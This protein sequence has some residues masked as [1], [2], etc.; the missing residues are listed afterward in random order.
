MKFPT[1]QLSPVSCHF[2]P[3]RSKHS[4]STP[5]SKPWSPS[6][7]LNVRDQVSNPYS[8]NIKDFV[9]KRFRLFQYKDDNSHALFNTQSD[10]VTKVEICRTLINLTGCDS[11]VTLQPDLE[12]KHYSSLRQKLPALRLSGAVQEWFCRRMLRDDTTKCRREGR[13]LGA[14][15][16]KW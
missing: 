16:W 4:L 8:W 12:L 9:N 11:L 15:N 3:L 2:I 14:T 1:V 5:I 10:Y 6:S 7:F 13:I